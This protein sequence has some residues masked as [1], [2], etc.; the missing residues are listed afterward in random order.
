MLHL[1]GCRFMAI[2][3]TCAFLVGAVRNESGE[4]RPKEDIASYYQCT[5]LVAG[6]FA[7]ASFFSLVA[8]SVGI[9]SYIATERAASSVLPPSPP[10]SEK[11]GKGVVMMDQPLHQGYPADHPQP[12]SAEVRTVKDLL[13]DDCA[14]YVLRD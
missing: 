6:V 8:A 7:G 5:V 4:R 1:E 13:E 9:T 12:G 14:N 10:W 3:S 2:L 11:L